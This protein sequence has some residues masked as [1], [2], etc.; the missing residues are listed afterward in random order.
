MLTMELKDFYLNTPM[1]RPEFIQIKMSDIP[2]DVIQ[3]Y[4]L[5]DTVEADGYVYCRVEKDMYGLPQS[6]IIAQDL[7]E[8]RLA[9]YGYSQSQL[10]PGLWKHES[11]PT[12]F[13]LVVDNFAIKYLTARTHIT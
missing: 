8:K 3:H 4:K 6:G 7:L 12:I 1:E 11:H 5:R 2:E 10:T 9:K 13:T